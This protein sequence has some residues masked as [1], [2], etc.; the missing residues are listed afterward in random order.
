MKHISKR[1]VDQ[2]GLVHVGI[3]TVI[4]TK[5]LTWTRSF[6]ACN[7][8]IRVCLTFPDWAKKIESVLQKCQSFKSEECGLGGNTNTH[9]PLPSFWNNMSPDDKKTVVAIFDKNGEYSVT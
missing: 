9:I 6:Q 2:W 8:Y 3:Y 5:I 4:S 1:V 7:I